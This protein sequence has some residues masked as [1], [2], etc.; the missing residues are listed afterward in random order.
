MRLLLLP[1][2]ILIGIFAVLFGFWCLFTRESLTVRDVDSVAPQVVLVDAIVTTWVGVH[3]NMAKDWI[4]FHLSSGFGHLF[5][6]FDNPKKDAA[7]IKQLE[8]DAEFKG[9]ITIIRSDPTFRQKYWIPIHNSKD[10]EQIMLPSYGV[11]QETEAMARQALHATRAAKMASDWSRDCFQSL[12]DH[13][14]STIQNKPCIRWLLHLDADELFV[15]APPTQVNKTVDSEDFI[16]KG[17]WLHGA[18]KH[19]L[20]LLSSSNLTHA[21]FL[22][23]EATWP[24]LS[25]SLAKK[26]NSEL[27]KSMTSPSVSP[28]QDGMTLIKKN[29]NDFSLQR[30]KNAQQFNINWSRKRGLRSNF[31]GYSCGK[32]GVNI[33][34]YHRFYSQ[35]QRQ[36]ETFEDRHQTIEVDDHII[37]N[38]VT[39]FYP[40]ASVAKLE[41]DFRMIQDFDAAAKFISRATFQRQVKDAAIQNLARVIHFINFSVPHVLDKFSRKPSDLMAYDEKKV[42]PTFKKTFSL[43]RDQWKQAEEQPAHDFYLKL[44]KTAESFTKSQEKGNYNPELI[45]LFDSAFSWESHNTIEEAKKT[46]AV[47]TSHYL[48]NFIKSLSKN[49]GSKSNVIYKVA[50][51]ELVDCPVLAP[52]YLCDVSLLNMNRRYDCCIILKNPIQTYNKRLLGYTRFGKLEWWKLGSIKKGDTAENARRRH[53]G[54]N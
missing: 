15:P 11:H 50:V 20:D 12:V 25:T 2:S 13:K 4:R 16:D 21:Q 48:S 1:T 40:S 17:L 23:D 22:N 19:I 10:P 29:P 46:T 31:M 24:I 5:I 45:K 54:V 53:T 34:Q 28:F 47:Y 30:S 44:S 8:R 26:E 18:S 38:G 52:D 41:A 43:W 6:F 35:L 36:H 14:K 9:Y 33:P 49:R 3:L 27:W 32:G 37:A 42:N 51:S 7:L 39:G